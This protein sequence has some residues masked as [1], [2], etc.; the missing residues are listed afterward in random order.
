MSPSC[1]QRDTY[2]KNVIYDSNNT[3]IYDLDIQ[4]TGKHR[5]YEKKKNSIN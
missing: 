5:F 3:L 1:E 2:I 4:S